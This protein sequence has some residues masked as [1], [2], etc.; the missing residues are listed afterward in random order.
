M[1][2]GLIGK[3][4]GM[5]QIFDER[6]VAQP[7]TI[8]EAGPCYVTQVRTPENEGYS[9]VQ[10][11]FGEQHPK[12]LSGGELG[13]LKAR[14]IPPLRF[15]REFRSKTIDVNIGDKV[16]V[17][18]F[19]VGERVDVVGVSK[20][21]GFAGTIKRHHFNRQP[22]THGASDRVRAP[23]SSGATTTP[24]RVYKGTRRAG[25]MGSDRVTVQGLKVVLVDAERNLLGLHGAVPGPKGGVIMIKEARKQ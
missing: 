5:T 12:R 10:L 2:K 20:G 13:H 9:A 4:I 1:L 22:K 11:G 17:E 25:H 16:T 24:G 3:K 14:E 19:A 21:K 7:V 23:G 8:I 15:L 18:T 6:G